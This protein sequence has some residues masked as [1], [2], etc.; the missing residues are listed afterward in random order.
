[1]LDQATRDK[2]QQTSRMQLMI[3]LAYVSSVVLYVFVTFVVVGDS[4]RKADLLG[5]LRA[6]FIGISVAAVGVNFWIQTRVLGNVEHYRN[7]RSIDELLKVNGRYFFISLALCQLP[8]LLALILV[9]LSMRMTEW[10]PFIVILVYMHAT[11]IP[12]AGRL[13]NIAQAHA[14]SSSQAGAE[15]NPGT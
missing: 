11:S 2:L 15:A 13:E 1:M 4:S 5:M 9:F 7:C 12:R 3:Y 8:A 6:I 14:M 10:W